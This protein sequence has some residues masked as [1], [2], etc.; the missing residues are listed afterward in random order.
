MGVS[1]VSAKEVSDLE[2]D[3]ARR[4]ILEMRLKITR[5]QRYRTIAGIFAKHGLLHLLEDRGLFRLFF[6]KRTREE[7]EKLHRFGR[8]L[9]MVFEELG[10]TF[11]KL[12]QVLVSRQEIIPEPV[13]T[14]LSELLN[15][16]PPM[17]FRYMAAVMEDGLPEGL[18]EFEWIDP[19]PVGSASLAQV[20]RAQLKDGRV[21]AVKVVRPIVDKLFEIDI[22][23]IQKFAAVAKK[24]PSP[25][26]S[27]SGFKRVG[28]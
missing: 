9:R 6:K 7:E 4:E 15:E 18:K 27:F 2:L 28:P 24:A 14:E 12:G 17:P 8:R 11:I 22:S 25:I 3:Q 20:Y 5:S 19:E 21:C 10:P 26:R 13:T 1:V 23:I 16:V